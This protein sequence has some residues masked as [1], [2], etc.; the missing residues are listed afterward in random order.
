MGLLVTLLLFPQALAF[1]FCGFNLLRSIYTGFI[2]VV[3]GQRFKPVQRC[4]FMMDM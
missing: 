3:L 2:N 4:F 1:S